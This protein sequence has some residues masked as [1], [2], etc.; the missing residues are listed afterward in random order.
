M[1]KLN[2]IQLNKS[3]ILTKLTAVIMTLVLMSFP[4]I[5]A[6]AAENEN[7]SVYKLADINL[8]VSVPTDLVCF[9]QNVTSNNAYLELIGADNVEELRSLMKIN[10]IFL[11]IVPKDVSYEILITGTNAGG[12]TALCD[13]SENDLNATFEAY[14]DSCQTLGSVNISEEITASYIY[15]Y[16]N[17]P[18]FVT[19]VTSKANSEVTIRLKKYYTIMMGKAVTISLQTNQKTITDEMETQLLNIVNSAEYKTIK[20]S[21][22]DNSFFAEIG[23]TIL[24]LI[25]PIAL[26][27]VI[28]LFVHRST[29]KT[30]RQIAEDEAR[31]RV[32][33]ATEKNAADEHQHS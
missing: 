17:I 33:Y 18:Y 4:C 26:L 14:L 21:I 27:A 19:E 5:Q 9:T 31:L 16:N 13:L 3:R 25:I 1:N 29:Q 7:T 28:A 23:S 11:E 8:Q 6:V 32:K 10:N 22:W 30:K 15:T 2:A 20:K 24:T 12:S